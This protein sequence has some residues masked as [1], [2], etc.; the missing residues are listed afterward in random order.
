[1]SVFSP[2]RKIKQKFFYEVLSICLLL[3]LMAWSHVLRENMNNNENKMYIDRVDV[4]DSIG[5]G[6]TRFEQLSRCD[7]YYFKFQIIN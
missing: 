6:T 5:E 4:G 3:E 2:F 1:M 7:L